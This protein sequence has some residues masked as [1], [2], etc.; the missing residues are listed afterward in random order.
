M[1]SPAEALQSESPPADHYLAAESK[2][3]AKGGV[4]VTIADELA[5]PIQYLGT[6]EKIEDLVEFD[7]Q[8]FADALLG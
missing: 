7:A 2:R 1:E 5:L 8:A 4:V 6:G 3:I